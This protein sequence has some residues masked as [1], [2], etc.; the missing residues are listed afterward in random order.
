MNERVALQTLPTKQ[1]LELEKKSSSSDETISFL[2]QNSNNIWGIEMEKE[3]YNGNE[4]PKGRLLEF[5]FFFLNFIQLKLL[6]F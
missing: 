2:G 6:K 5:L 3:R 1:I 4:S